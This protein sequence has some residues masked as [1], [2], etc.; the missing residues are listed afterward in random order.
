MNL[1]DDSFG[2]VV[3]RP[4]YSSIEDCSVPPTGVTI[5][6]SRAGCVYTFKEN[7]IN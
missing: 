2:Y 4:L 1:L 3:A 6:K 5:K 7:S